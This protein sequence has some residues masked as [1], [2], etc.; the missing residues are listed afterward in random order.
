MEDATEPAAGTRAILAGLPVLLVALA[1]MVTTWLATDEGFHPVPYMDAWETVG[2]MQEIA[3]HG[4]S[5]ALLRRQHNEHRIVVPRL[6][7][8][9]DYSWF[10]GCGH[11][12]AVCLF[13][14]QALHWLVL[15]VLVFQ[16]P[17]QSWSGRLMWGWIALGSMFWAAQIQN[18][19]QPFQVSFI[20]AFAAC[21]TAILCAYCGGKSVTERGFIL[22]FAAMVFW[23]MV[24]TYSLACGL[25]VWPVLVVF[26]ALARWRWW[27]VVLMVAA[28]GL[29]I[30]S[31]LWGYANHPGHASPAESL[32]HPLSVA[33]Y[34]AAWLGGP[35]HMWGSRTAMALGG[36]GLIAGGGAGAW[37]L[38]R[39]R[40]NVWL[41]AVLA[42]MAVPVGSAFLTALGRINFG[43]AQ[44]FATRYAT[45]AEVYWILL[46]AVL[47]TLVPSSRRL[48]AG[49][50]LGILLAAA[51]AFIWLPTQSRA[52]REMRSRQDRLAQ[53]ALSLSLRAN[54]DLVEREVYPVMQRLRGHRD[55][56][57]AMGKG[58]LHREAEPRIGTALTQY[59]RSTRAGRCAGL[60]FASPVGTNP[61]ATRVTGRLFNP[62]PE[63]R[64]VLWFDDA[65]KLVGA[66]LCRPTGVPG[67]WDFA[68]YIV[69]AASEGHDWTMVAEYD[70][71][72]V[73][74]LSGAMESLVISTAAPANLDPE[75]LHAD[76]GWTIDGVPPAAG[77]P[78]GGGRVWGS[79][80]KAGSTT[81]ELQVRFN[82]PAG[83][84]SV[85]LPIVTGPGAARGTYTLTVSAGAVHLEADLPEQPVRQWAE[86]HVLIPAEDD[87]RTVDLRIADN[88]PNPG[89]WIA[90]GEPRP[91]RRREADA[92]P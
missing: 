90:I 80:S 28:A 55:L 31:Y 54:D 52:L 27:R 19:V 32:R 72:T 68:G 85:R 49:L 82:R 7:A 51:C 76:D 36:L 21:D 2:E 13:V 5:W 38:W 11:L 24:A 63:L 8:W 56:L 81:G 60:A 39:E 69:T 67:A 86:L 88:G 46:L 25:V 64:R 16:G 10:G 83:V 26:A 78:A 34:M 47:S 43:Y 3:E 84:S 35:F 71:A 44:A 65:K 53:A 1:V 92:A 9:A 42:A 75:V 62:D 4:C 20:L 37:Y 89:Q 41:T 58:W 15:V 17:W 59:A 45:P 40:R 23:G 33:Q 14:F 57:D 6:I 91:E 74:E 70:D 61:S 73:G 29:S 79:W 87:A 66:A 77:M 22:W 12:Q 18:F 50:G 30:G 48:R